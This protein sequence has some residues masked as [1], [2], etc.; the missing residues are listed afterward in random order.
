MEATNSGPTFKRSANR[1]TVDRYVRLRLIMMVWKM[2][3]NVLFCVVPPDVSLNKSK[4]E[5]FMFP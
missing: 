5:L 3:L 2:L 1:E 4:M